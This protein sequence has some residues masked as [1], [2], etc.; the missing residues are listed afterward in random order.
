MEFIG[1]FYS[2]KFKWGFD[3]LKGRSILVQGVGHVGE[4]LVKI[5]EEGYKIFI[6]DINENKLIQVSEKFDSEI[7]LGESIYDMDIDIYAPSCIRINIKYQYNK[8]T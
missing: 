8:S 4:N 1:E 3:S 2:L 6:T 7:V 5:S